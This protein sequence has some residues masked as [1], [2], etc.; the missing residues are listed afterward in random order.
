MDD[1]NIVRSIVMIDDDAEFLHVMQRRLQA[2]KADYTTAA[3]V[4]IKT[5]TDPVEAVVSLPPDGITVVLVDYN[6][7]G[8]TG[9]D[10]LPKMLKAGAGPV[11]LLTNQNDAKLAADAFRAGA[12]DFVTKADMVAN[13]SALART[14]RE[15]VQ[16]HRL[17]TRN[18]T[19]SRELK[20]LN[21]ELEVKNKKLAE[22]T[23]T[24]H[25]FVDDVAHD[26]RTPLTVIQQYASLACD[27]AG[28]PPNDKQMKYLST[29]TDATRELAEMIDDFLD[30]SKLRSRTLPVYRQAHPVQELFDSIRPM[31]AVR[32]EPKQIV[33]KWTISDGIK[34]FFGDLSKAGRVLSNLISNAI[35]V[36]PLSQPLHLWAEQTADGDVKIG[37]T[38]VGPGLKPQQ[39]EVIFQRFKQLEEP[40]ITG[41][42]GFGLGLSIV[43]QLAWLN[44]GAVEVQSELGKGST[45]AFTLPGLDLPRILTCFL[46]CIRARERADDIWMLKIRPQ[47][48]MSDISMFRRVISTFS[49]PMDLV[50]ESKDR[51]SINVLGSSRDPRAWAARIRQEAARFHRSV[52]SQDVHDLMVETVG[53]WPVGTDAVKLISALNVSH[54]V[55]V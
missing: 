49:Y 52:T 29:I 24:A 34:P 31:L 13:S 37:V 42:K 39:L 22:L 15:A 23:E 17:E 51:Q 7:P 18:Q 45:F 11:I 38:D 44:L 1:C 19:L 47:G 41:A 46:T 26:F 20:L 55:E 3:N 43:K 54:L 16:R 12:A 50:L 40:Q 21:A 27:D 9:I 48:A 30:S 32:A 14:I 53:P 2:I 28:G 33:I 35:K 10:W 25:Q 6:M 36:T 4:D 8:G 5:F